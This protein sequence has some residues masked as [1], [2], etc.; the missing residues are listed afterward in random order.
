V[1]MFTKITGVATAVATDPFN[2][3]S[4]SNAVGASNS[5]LSSSGVKT[6]IS[7]QQP[8]F[9]PSD[10]SLLEGSAV[11]SRNT[12]NELLPS[13]SSRYVSHEC[14]FVGDLI[15]CAVVVAAGCEFSIASA[16]T[17]RWN[18]VSFIRP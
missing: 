11:Q 12:L 1:D 15:V 6:L 2:K 17:K 9:G 13:V 18:I 5:L 8:G 14:S 4:S 10:S 16:P 3:A 7:A